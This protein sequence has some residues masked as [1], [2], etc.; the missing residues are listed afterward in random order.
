MIL[1]LLFLISST[2]LSSDAQIPK[3]K[4]TLCVFYVQIIYGAL[5]IRNAA[6]TSFALCHGMLL[7]PVPGIAVFWATLKFYLYIVDIC[8]FKFTSFLREIIFL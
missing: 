5:L 6:E 7:P 1:L 2:L 4:N 8:T 3:F